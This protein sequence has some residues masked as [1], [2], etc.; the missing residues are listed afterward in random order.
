MSD[1]AIRIEI[2]GK[3]S[4]TIAKNIRDIANAALEADTNLDQLR[5]ALASFNTSSQ[6]IKSAATDT[7][8]LRSEIVKATQSQRT[9]TTAVKDGSA[10][11][12]TSAANARK[13]S[14][15]LNNAA[16]KSR[17]LQNNTS[18]LRGALTTVAGLFGGIFA[19]KHYAD[20]Q[21][22]LTTIQNKIKQVTTT[23]Q[24]QIAVQEELF[25]IANR[26]RT[27]VSGVADAFLRYS[28]AMASAGK[29]TEYVL[30]F[31]EVLSMAMVN[32]G[33]NTQEV[34]SIVTQLGQALTAGRLNGDE[35]RSLR[36][37]LP[38]E[39]LESFAKQLGVGRDQLGKMAEQGKITTDVML[40]GFEQNEKLIREM[41]TRTMPTISAAFTIL[42][43]KFI[44]FTA[45][46]SGMANMLAHTIISIG[47]N[48]HIIIPAVLAFGAA[49][50]AV[51]MAKII[52]EFA[53]LTKAV[54]VGTVAFAAANLTVLVWVAA[55]GLVATALLAVAYA[56]AVATGNAENFEAFIAESIIKAKEWAAGMLGM[57]DATG[58]ASEAQKILGEAMDA[59]NTAITGAKAAVSGLTTAA[60]DNKAAVKDWSASTTKAVNAVATSYDNLSRAAKA[61]LAAAGPENYQKLVAAGGSSGSFQALGRPTADSKGNTASFTRLDKI[62]GY[63]NG[64]S[65]MVGGAAGVDR[66]LVSFKASRGERVDVSTPSQQRKQ[67]KG[68]SEGG[69][70][71]YFNFNIQTRDAQSFRLSRNQLAS[72]VQGALG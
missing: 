13:Y 32:A 38:V 39:V 34:S 35:F 15:E 44:E 1:E 30:N 11:L 66:N 31:V 58:L 68:S 10:A 9:F 20:A 63:R 56:V 3:I 6:V 69:V 23:T 40:A 52:M 33:K 72:D 64:G 57:G 70:R 18:T 55:L 41:F 47:D 24:Q 19:V 5:Q 36:E 21:D 65:F 27:G 26:T 37:N 28:K 2:T 14:T 60:N 25:R 16:N 43:N 53:N 54:I 59:S 50:A 71:N 4:G 45:S 22:A 61:A 12:A 49:W 62:K 46:S 17:Q 48:L 7:R 8:T 42:N 67:A 29:D 51:G